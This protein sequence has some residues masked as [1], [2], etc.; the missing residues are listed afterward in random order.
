MRMYNE[1]RLMRNEIL[2]VFALVTSQRNL[3]LGF[4]SNKNRGKSSVKI[5]K[6]GVSKGGRAGWSCSGLK[7]G[8]KALD[9]KGKNR[10]IA[11]DPL[12][13]TPTKQKTTTAKDQQS[14][15]PTKQ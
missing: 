9:Q 15:R 2:K 3:T 12:S 10:A 13:T 14:H 6:P 11:I 4:A 5:P 1:P 7:S 8:K